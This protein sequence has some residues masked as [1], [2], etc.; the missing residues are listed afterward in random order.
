MVISEAEVCSEGANDGAGKNVNTMMVEVEPAGDTDK[1]SCTNWQ[2]D[3]EEE[4][5]DRWRSCAITRRWR[6]IV[7]LRPFVVSC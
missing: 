3:C 5:V 4:Q 6:E 2:E 1:D 7:L